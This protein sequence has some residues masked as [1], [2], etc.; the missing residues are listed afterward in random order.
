MLPEAERS[1]L[2][3]E[4]LPYVRALAA[5]IKEQLPPEIEYEELVAYGTQGLLEAAQRFDP[6][7]G[8]SFS[9][10]AYYRIR[11]AIFDGLRQMG[12]LSRGAYGRQRTEDKITSYLSAVADRDAAADRAGVPGDLEAEVMGLSDALAGVATI[13]VTSLAAIDR[14][15]AEGG[16]S[17]DQR[18]DEARLGHLVREALAS[19]PDKERK[20]L[21]LHYFK[22]KSLQEAGK[23][24]GL[25]KSW[26]SRLHARA[27]DLLRAAF[28]RAQR[29]P[30]RAPPER[31]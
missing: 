7:G 31:K 18:L 5:Q 28:E 3:D 14:Q 20:L 23:E 30:G 29:P 8:A 21:D 11:G 19:L 2:V 27:V 10:Y 6:R 26:A 13:F 15:L 24:L 17:T 9:T 1:R 22:S 4:N 16:P 25:S 12:W